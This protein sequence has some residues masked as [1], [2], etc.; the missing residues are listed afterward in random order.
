MKNKSEEYIK[1]HERFINDPV[2]K[3]FND[4]LAF[5]YTN[6][7]PKYYKEV[8]GSIKPFY[9]NTITKII[10]DIEEAR[11]TH[12]YNNYKSLTYGTEDITNKLDD[13]LIYAIKLVLQYGG[14]TNMLQKRM[15]ISYKEA[16]EF[17]NE[18]ELFGVVGAYNG[19]KPREVLI[20]NI[21][22]IET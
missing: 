18:M 6:T 15:A 10:K 7:I 13:D 21:N 4:K 1:L 11:D 20:N 16:T 12:I 2:I 22:E 5:I 8:N 3:E 17:M 9:N 14:S 19:A